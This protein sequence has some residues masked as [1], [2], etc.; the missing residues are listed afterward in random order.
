MA[1]T[2]KQIKQFDKAPEDINELNQL[3]LETLSLIGIPEIRWEDLLE[4][5][6]SERKWQLIK[7]SRQRVVT[8]DVLAQSCVKFLKE[9]KVIHLVEHRKILKL[10]KF[11]SCE[12][13]WEHRRNHSLND[14]TIWEDWK[15]L[16]L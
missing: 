2:L 9:V 14:S 11:A 1:A 10:V 4:K 6:D 5:E 7:A 13:F 12:L 15:Q 8:G 3:Y 16:I